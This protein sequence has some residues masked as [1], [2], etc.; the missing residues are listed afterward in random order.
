MGKDLAAVPALAVP[1]SSTRV[2]SSSSSRCMIKERKTKTETAAIAAA[3][4]A[5]LCAVGGSNFESHYILV[6]YFGRRRLLIFIARVLKNEL[7]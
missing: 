4:T 1:C 5:K 3:G 2:T 7:R 6:R